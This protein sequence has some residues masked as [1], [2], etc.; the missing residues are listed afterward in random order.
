MPKKL[1]PAVDLMAF[2][3][4]TLKVN[5]GHCDSERNLSSHGIQTEFLSAL[6]EVDCCTETRVC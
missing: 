3:C 5:I 2:K 6:L 4:R 1:R